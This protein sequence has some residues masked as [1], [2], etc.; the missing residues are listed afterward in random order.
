M[1]LKSVKE[2]RKQLPAF[3]GIATE[4][5]EEKKPNVEMQNKVEK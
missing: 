2:K 5:D 4:T 1:F 3:S